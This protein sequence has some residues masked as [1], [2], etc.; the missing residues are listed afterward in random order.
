MVRILMAGSLRVLEMHGLE[1]R[2]VENIHELIFLTQI[3]W[4][5]KE[6]KIENHNE[7]IL[8]I[9][10]HGLRFRQPHT[11]FHAP[12]A[13]QA[14]LSYIKRLDGGIHSCGVRSLTGLKREKGSNKKPWV[15]TRN[16]WLPT[17][18]LAKRSDHFLSA[19]T[20][21]LLLRSS[22]KSLKVVTRNHWIPSRK[23]D[24]LRSKPTRN[25]KGLQFARYTTMSQSQSLSQYIYFSNTS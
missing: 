24:H 13:L 8:I 1:A 21:K 16:H 4:N 23:S 7:N 18:D 9:W 2:F 3:F 14:C 17:R 19:Q 11:F 22:K 5:I 10:K 15:V 20:R 25:S 12:K 6:F